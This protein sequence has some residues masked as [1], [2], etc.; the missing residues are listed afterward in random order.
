MDGFSRVLIEDFAEVLGEE[1]KAHLDRIRH[2]AGD[3]SHMIDGLLVL[4]R[5]TRAELKL[6][7]VDLTQIARSVVATL[8]QSAPERQAEVVVEDGLRTRADPRLLRIVLEN[9]LGNAWKFTRKRDVAHIELR[10][11]RSKDSVVYVVRD[12]G[13]GFEMAYADKLF[14]AFRRLHSPREFEGTGIGLATVL[15][16]VRRHGGRVWG[17]GEVGKG[18]AFSF[19]LG[20]QAA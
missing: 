12:D 5:A 7:E 16:I 3:M 8:K 11:R 1:G 10:A 18:A 6:E 15:R 17:V 13:A 20:E 19:T 9:L 4:S 2:A 14:G